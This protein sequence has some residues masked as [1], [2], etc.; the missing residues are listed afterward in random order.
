MPLPLFLFC[1]ISGNVGYST[2]VQNSTV[3]QL[4]EALL[5]DYDKGVRP[6]KDWTQ[7]TTIYIDFILH[8]VLDVDGQNQKLTTS[9]WY[10]QLWLDEHLVWNASSFDG[11][12]EISL[13]VDAIWIPDIIIQEFID[14]G[15]S[16]YLPYVYVNA[17]GAVK[18][19][20]P[21]QV[22]SA[23]NL[24][25]Y[26]FPFDKQNCTFTFCSWLHTVN[27]VNLKFWRSFDEIENDTR[28]FLGDGEW[29]L[30]SVPSK[31][32]RIHD[33]GKDYAQIQFN[34]VIRRRPLLYVV[35]LLLPSIFLM[36]VD[37]TS[38]FLPPGSSGRITFKSSIL[39][40][41]TVFRMNLHDELP[42]TALRTPLIGVFFAV[43]IALLVISLAESILIVQ[44]LNVNEEAEPESSVSVDS[45][46]KQGATDSLG[47]SVKVKEETCD[48][49]VS[50]S[51]PQQE[52]EKF[53][54]EDAQGHWTQKLPMKEI[55]E[56]ISSI[57]LYL[58]QL[59]GASNHKNEWL[60]FCYRLDRVFFLVYLVTFGVYTITM[61]TLWLM[62]SYP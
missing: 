53:L 61:T 17:S 43:C 27:D 12:N 30:L 3:H 25:I 46:A 11:I 59:D 56:E 62:W 14:V 44:L 51:D 22:V 26:A 13:P 42:I 28:A 40:G 49:G 52:E 60:A 20:K 39:L 47:T 1:L 19:Y 34:I 36:L 2:S 10:R 45:S 32:E 18:N 23:C 24:E 7:P 58:H 31:Y 6:V 5:W 37:V 16:P 15:R 8:A 9:V 57:R 41:Y 29:E 54:N 33:K 35:S 4:T 48:D 38:Y 55:Q 50:E 21:M